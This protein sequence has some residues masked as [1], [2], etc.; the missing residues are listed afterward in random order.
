M[1]RILIAGVAIVLLG[2][3]WVVGN[4][5]WGQVNSNDNNIA[6][7]DNCDASDPAWGTVGFPV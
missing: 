3:S 4:R 6:V 5:A 7:M 2:G 1:R